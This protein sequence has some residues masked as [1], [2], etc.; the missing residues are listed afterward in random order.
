MMR[1]SC[2][3]AVVV[4]C[5]CVVPSLEDWVLGHSLPIYVLHLYVLASCWR[6]TCCMWTTVT[7]VS[8]EAY[9]SSCT[10][11]NQALNLYV[12]VYCLCV[13]CF[14]GLGDAKGLPP[15]IPRVFS[16]RP[17]DLS[18]GQHTAHRCV[19]EA[20]HNDDDAE[21]TQAVILSAATATSWPRQR[22]CFTGR[23][24]APTVCGRTLRC[25]RQMCPT[26]ATFWINGQ[27]RD[28][29]SPLVGG[30]DDLEGRIKQRLMAH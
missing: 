1:T 5:H 4:G 10:T 30:P 25:M 26:R 9:I 12:A 29:C 23:P 17:A 2:C 19:F 27:V 20:E 16:L 7:G 6:S 13:Q 14:G 11:Y 28:D 21:L 18:T 22:Q 3:A 24:G 8:C 15:H